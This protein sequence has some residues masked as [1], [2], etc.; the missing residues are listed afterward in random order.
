LWV[1]LSSLPLGVEVAQTRLFLTL[2]AFELVL[3]LTCRSLKYT[4]VKAIP[5]KLLDATIIWE[6][7]LISIIVNVPILRESFG[8]TVVSI[9]DVLL[10]VGLAAVVLVTIEVTKRLLHFHDPKFKDDKALHIGID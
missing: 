4:I 6:I 5:H 10:I 8:L 9:N 2:I 1:F 7:I 3:A